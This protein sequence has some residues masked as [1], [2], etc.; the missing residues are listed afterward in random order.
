MRKRSL[1]NMTYMVLLL[2]HSDEI[3][4]VRKSS[5]CECDGQFAQKKDLS[6]K[7]L[8]PARRRLWHLQASSL[9]LSTAG[10]NRREAPARSGKENCFYS[11]TSPLA[12]PAGP[13]PSPARTQRHQPLGPKGA[14]LV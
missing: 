4:G 6:A 11:Q 7:G 3:I 12:C 1:D 10:P 14:V 8:K 9:S 5:T 13:P 2:R